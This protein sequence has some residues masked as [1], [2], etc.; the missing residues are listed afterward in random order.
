M[1]EQPDSKPFL[2]C[3]HTH[4]TRDLCKLDTK[5]CRFCD[6]VR[7]M[8]VESEKMSA[9]NAPEAAVQAEHSPRG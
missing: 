4:G 5:L 8:S 7:C 9:D 6:S 3:V 2:Q 1:I